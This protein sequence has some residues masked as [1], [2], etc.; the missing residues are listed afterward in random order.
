MSRAHVRKIELISV[1]TVTLDSARTLSDTLES[2][3]RQEGV[4]VENI[5]KDGG[6]RDTTLEI[7][8]SQPGTV[9]IIEQMDCGIYDAMNQ[10]FAVAEGQVVCF[11]NSDDY[12]VDSKVLKDVVDAFEVSGADIVYG[13]VEI[14]AENGVVLRHWRSGDLDN[15]R[16]SGQQLPHPAFFVRSNLLDEIGVPFDSSYRISA[17]FKQQVLLIN[18]LGAKTHYLQRTLV[19]M[20]HGGASSRNLRAFFDGWAECARA[21]RDVTGSNGWVFV[22]KKVARK[23]QHLGVL[24]WRG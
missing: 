14:V 22:F 1:V 4:S 16:L 8:R 7:A 21:Y 13:D 10:G 17:D 23:F 2:V 6:S 15:G 20:R 3:Y 12:F 19:R 9:R 5:V 11:L 18:Q 24:R